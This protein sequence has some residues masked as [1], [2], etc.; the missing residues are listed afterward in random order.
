MMLTTQGIGQ[1]LTT[2][3]RYAVQNCSS[4]SEEPVRSC[5]RPDAGL[6][7]VAKPNMQNNL[8]LQLGLR[9]TLQGQ[10]GSG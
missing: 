8:K 3:L 1:T 7:R 9:R 6:S 2:V 10:L 5:K 4:L